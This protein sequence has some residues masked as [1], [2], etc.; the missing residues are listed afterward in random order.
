MRNRLLKMSFILASLSILAICPGI[1]RADVT[2]EHYI[3]SGGVGGVGAHEAT[4]VDY[5]KGLKKCTN[6]KFKFTGKVLGFLTKENNTSA[7]YLVKK[8]ILWKIDH[9]DK[10]FTQGTISL[11]KS[12]DRNEKYD[13][14]GEKTGGKQTGEKEKKV[15]I[16]RNELKMKKTGKTK[17]INGF[18]CEEYL[19]TWLIETEDIET[20][21]RS[22]SLMTGDFW[23]TPETRAIKQLM[24][25]ENGFNRAY[26]KKLGLNIPPGFA[27]N[28]GL[29]ILGSLQGSQGN[30]LTDEMK[31]MKGYP[32]VTSIKWETSGDAN[33]NKGEAKGE[34]KEEAPSDIKGAIGG[35]FAK[36]AKKVIKK[37]SEEKGEMKTAFDSYV[38]I[39]S[40]STASIPN[41]QFTVPAGYKKK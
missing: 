27:K 16:V 15:R 5:I 21:E 40:I 1:L 24:K 29:S 12:K 28:F 34:E 30:K 13:S 20:K 31:K 26:M 32:I 17:T 3:K 36:A 6:S 35:F 41:S 33:N 11:P 10:T 22:K 2:V 19:L 7:V 18:K 25:E 38:E 39:K 37:K 23:N 8:D 4:N 9:K 14:K